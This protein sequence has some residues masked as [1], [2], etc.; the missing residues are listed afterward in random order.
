MTTQIA[1]R[2]P[3]DLVEL[4]DR[5]VRSGEAP[6]RDDIVM[7]ALRRELRRRR[8]IADLDRFG[9]DYADDLDALSSRAS[10]TTLELD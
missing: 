3:D 8:A 5:L 7:R 1:V 2:L 9:D 4:L 6:S 10:R